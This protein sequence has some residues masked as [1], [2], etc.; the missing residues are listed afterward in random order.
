MMNS[1]RLSSCL[2]AMLLASPI[3]L[4]DT[5]AKW[6]FET[7]PPAGTPGAGVWITNIVAEA[8]SGTASGLHAGAATYSSP[9]GNGSA[10]SFSST[11]WAAGDFY[12]FA[13][14]TLGFQNL[15]VSFDITKSATGPG[16]AALQ[17]STDGSTFT[18][19]GSSFLVLTN[20]TGFPSWNATTAYSAYTMSFDL[21]SVTVLNNASVVYFRVEAAAA[22]TSSSGTLRVDNFLVSGAS[23]VLPIPLNIQRVGTNVVLTWSDSAFALQAAP[24]VTGTY[25]NIPG[26]ANTNAYT[27]PIAGRQKFYRLVH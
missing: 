1:K 17:Y 16:T 27:E 9:V 19:F 22:P 14:S 20:G 11:V 21:S 23:Q 8:G 5:I 7:S 25:T 24:N 2:A 15:S 4:A 6:T 18:Q 12:Q 26:V 10:N 13:V 3:A